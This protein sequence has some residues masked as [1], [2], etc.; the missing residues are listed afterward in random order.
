MN[1]EVGY[2]QSVGSTVRVD[3]GRHQYPA[4]HAALLVGDSMASHYWLNI[5]AISSD[6]R[7]HYYITDE[8]FQQMAH[9]IHVRPDVIPAF[10][11]ICD[12]YIVDWFAAP[13]PM[14]NC[15]QD[16]SALMSSVR[17]RLRTYE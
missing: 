15:I 1:Q 9:T 10:L 12:G 4:V 16:P 14:P 17:E 13:L 6:A 7:F 5:L 2:L 11:V 8:D 3:Y